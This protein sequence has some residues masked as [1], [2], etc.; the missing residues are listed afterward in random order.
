MEAPF[1]GA[2]ARED[3]RFMALPKG[4]NFQRLQ[5]PNRGKTEKY[6]LGRMPVTI[7][8]KNHV[9]CLNPIMKLLEIFISFHN[10][11]FDLKT[12]FDWSCQRFPL[13]SFYLL[14][15]HIFHVGL[16]GETCH[17]IFLINS[18]FFCLC[19]V[20]PVRPYSLHIT[21]LFVWC[22]TSQTLQPSHNGSVCV[23]LNQSDLTAF[24]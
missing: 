4:K 13:D 17:A 19:G 7:K 3:L 2:R 22:W 1:L 20:E 16:G 5:N 9:D 6:F 18:W 15:S 21:G 11:V 23:V 12:V 8:F 14:V 24:T 10:S